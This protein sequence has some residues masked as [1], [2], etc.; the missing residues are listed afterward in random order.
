MATTVAWLITRPSTRTLWYVASTQRYR[1][2]PVSGRVRNAATTVSSSP[3]IRD[4]SDFEIPSSAQRLHQVIDLPRR[5]AVHVRLLDDREQRVLGAPARLQQR[6]EIRARP[7]LRDRQLD[8]A[9]PRVPRPRPR[10][11]CDRPSG[12]RVRSWRSA[13]ISPATSVSISACEST[14]MPSR[15]T[16]PSCSSRSLPTNADRSILGLA[17]VVNTSVS[18]FSCQRELTERCAMAASLSTPRPLPNF[19]HVLG[20]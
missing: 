9:H 6:R 14:R 5:D 16:S 17:I 19:H 10:R 15:S 11:R 7:H 3:Q 4:T 8:R 18:S 2:S 20:L 1:C 13:P 12:R